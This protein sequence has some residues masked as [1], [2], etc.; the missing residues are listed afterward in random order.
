MMSFTSHNYGNFDTNQLIRH[1]RGKRKNWQQI[2]KI[3]V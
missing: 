3:H 2:E 1:F